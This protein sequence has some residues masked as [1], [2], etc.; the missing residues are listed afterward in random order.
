M[1]DGTAGLG[2]TSTPYTLRGPLALNDADESKHN[3]LSDQ[4]TLIKEST[5]KV[6]TKYMDNTDPYLLKICERENED[7]YC[8][9][10]GKVRKLSLLFSQ[11]VKRYH[12]QYL[13]SSCRCTASRLK[14]K[15]H[16]TS[17]SRH[18]SS[19]CDDDASRS[20]LR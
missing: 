19:S 8:E 3:G 20:I 14:I 18:T 17:N 6:M 7:A 13:C 2:Q 15:D 12:H 9:F 16:W 4:D 5:V 1:L 11:E 10:A